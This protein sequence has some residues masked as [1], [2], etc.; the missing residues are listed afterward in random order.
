MWIGVPLRGHGPEFGV[1][2]LDLILCQ[3]YTLERLIGI[4]LSLNLSGDSPVV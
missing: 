4:R 3:S 1:D 2:D